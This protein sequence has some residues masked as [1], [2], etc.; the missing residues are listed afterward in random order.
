V[1]LSKNGT[2]GITRIV[3]WEDEFSIFVSL[4]LLRPTQAIKPEYL[5]ESLRSTYVQSQFGGRA[6]Q[7][8]VTNLHLIEIRQCKIPVTDARKQEE[9]VLASRN[10]DNLLSEARANVAA[11]TSLRKELLNSVFQ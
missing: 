2:I 6:K 7:G 11:V 4:C 8:T 5:A 1:L 9:V 3:T 10:F